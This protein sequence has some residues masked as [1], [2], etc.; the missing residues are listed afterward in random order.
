MHSD[1]EHQRAL[2]TPDVMLEMNG[3]SRNK[4]ICTLS[5]GEPKWIALGRQINDLSQSAEG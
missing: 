5:D 2:N 4:I 3:T 1:T